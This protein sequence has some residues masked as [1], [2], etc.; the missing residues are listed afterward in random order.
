MLV[1]GVA[2]DKGG[3]A[4]FGFSYYEQN[5]DK[6]NLVGVDNGKGCVKPDA[7]KIQSGEYDLLSRPLFMYVSD[8]SLKDNDTVKKFM[9]YVL[10]ND[11]AIAK[12]AQIVPD[13][14]EQLEKAK[15]AL[16]D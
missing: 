4:Y 13:T 1:E 7:A 15:T 16:G 8:K 6:L 11:E 5:K 10:E 12:A 9:D 3:L 14:P 2:G